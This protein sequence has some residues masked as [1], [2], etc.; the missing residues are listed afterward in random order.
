MFTEN[1]IV[2]TEG[3]MIDGQ[4]RVKMMGF[5]PPQQRHESLDAIGTFDLFRT[6]IT[7]QVKLSSIAT[8]LPALSLSYATH[9]CLYIYYWKSE[10]SD[11]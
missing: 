9:L 5:P 7:P 8:S 11:N 2:L 4:F 10:F 3:E 6:G 1:C